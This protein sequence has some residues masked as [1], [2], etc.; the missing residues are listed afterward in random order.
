[1]KNTAQ[2]LSPSTDLLAR[3]DDGPANE[4]P[5]GAN[6]GPSSPAERLALARKHVQ[7]IRGVWSDLK[8]QTID[9]RKS[10]SGKV[11][12]RMVPPLRAL[13][14]L[15]STPAWK[16]VFSA[17]GVGQDPEV[18]IPFDPAQLLARADRYEA[19]QGLHAELTELSAQVAD[20]LLHHG[21]QIVSAGKPAI[22]LARTLAQTNPVFRGKVA[23][24]LNELNT[25]TASARKGGEAA[26]E[27]TTDEDAGEDT[28]SGKEPDA[29]PD[30]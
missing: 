3:A 25:M 22:G 16:P 17:L 24:I 10:S 14:Q 26:D 18:H 23:P 21:A 8:G 5:H 30:A 13:F 11:A 7:S 15:A 19:L 29:K 2:K 12:A 9:E 27:E 28:A 6:D 4:G 1:M 20:D